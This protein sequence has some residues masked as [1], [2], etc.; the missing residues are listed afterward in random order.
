MVHDFG[1]A[2]EKGAQCSGSRW[3]GMCRLSA[4]GTQNNA[5]AACA[6]RGERAYRQQQRQKR[7]HGDALRAPRMQGPHVGLSAGQRARALRSALARSAQ[8]SASY[9]AARARGSHLP[10]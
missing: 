2:R 10:R 3:I 1:R 5:L 4:G 9:T 8:R 6:M 7:D